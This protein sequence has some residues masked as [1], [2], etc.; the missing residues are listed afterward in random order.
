MKLPLN[1]ALIGN[2]VNWLTIVVIVIFV[3]YSAFL[4]W[5][6]APFTPSD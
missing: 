6:I 2:P 4:L 1:L 5:Q 3:F